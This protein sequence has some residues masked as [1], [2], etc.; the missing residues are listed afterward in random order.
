MNTTTATR[1]MLRR[2][3]AETRAAELHPA[4]PAA[5]SCQHEH[6]API[7]APARE[8]AHRGLPLSPIV[9]AGGALLGVI[10]LLG[11]VTAA[12]L[13]VALVALALA[14]TSVVLVLLVKML[15]R[16]VSR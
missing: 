2:A 16:E 6:H 8:M 5:C 14:V 3:I 12:L 10:A 7:A 15:K 4:A 13:A 11:M 9:V 1:A